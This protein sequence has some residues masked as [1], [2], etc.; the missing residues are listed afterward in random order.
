MASARET[1]TCIWRIS[2]ATGGFK[3][4]QHP[5]RLVFGKRRVVAGKR[6]QEIIVAS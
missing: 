4:R 6:R 3:A 5:S 2:Q 1:Q